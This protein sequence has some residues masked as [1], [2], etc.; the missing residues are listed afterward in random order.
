MHMVKT[1]PVYL[2]PQLHM[3]HVTCFEWSTTKKWDPQLHISTK[4]IF[5][6]YLFAYWLL[7]AS[8]HGMLCLFFSFDLCCVIFL[9]STY[10]QIQYV[11][12][13]TRR[14]NDTLLV[15]GLTNLKLL[16]YL[17]ILNRS[18]NKF[19]LKVYNQKFEFYFTFFFQLMITN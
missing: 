11:S 3:D 16:N 8:W 13:T 10:V 5:L 17:R 9:L 1:G 4:V 2:I 6:N 7:L 18:L 19:F 12:S 15:Q 14:T